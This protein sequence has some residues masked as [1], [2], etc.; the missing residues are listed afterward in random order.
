[1]FLLI[2]ELV[3]WLMRLNAE[4]K[5]EG[6]TTAKGMFSEKLSSA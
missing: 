4:C 2:V 6:S 3:E 5:V 1:M